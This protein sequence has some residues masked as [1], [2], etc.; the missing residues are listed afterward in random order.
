FLMRDLSANPLDYVE[1]GRFEA[2][3]HQLSEWMDSTD[4]NLDM[5]YKRGGK[6]IVAIGTNDTLGSP[7]A[8]LD[9][10]QSVLDKMGRGKVDE[11]ARFFVLPQT[12]HGLSG[13]NYSTDGEGKSIPAAP[14]PN[15]FSRFELLVNWV[16]KTEAPPMAVTVKAGDRSLPMCSYPAYPKYNDGPTGAASSYACAVP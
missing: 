9:Y 12:G 1:G 13:T 6:M 11:F 2:R 8:Q 14:I 10:F 7:G 5:F 15:A 3:R 4:P 16:E